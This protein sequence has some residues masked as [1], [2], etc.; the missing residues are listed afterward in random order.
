M[1]RPTESGWLLLGR[2]NVEQKRRHRRRVAFYWL[3]GLAAIAATMVTP[4][5][6]LDTH[7]VWGPAAFTAGMVSVVANIKLAPWLYRRAGLADDP[8]EWEKHGG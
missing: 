4:I 2:L 1:T 7:D 5:W 3:A 6:W 8:I